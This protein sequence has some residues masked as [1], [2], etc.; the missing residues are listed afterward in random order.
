MDIFGR[1]QNDY[2]HLRELEQRS[3]QATVTEYLTAGAQAAG[4]PA[5]S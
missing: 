4:R 3:G 2:R 5:H 1:E